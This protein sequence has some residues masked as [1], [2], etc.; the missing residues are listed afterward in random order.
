MDK[1]NIII[2]AILAV[3][4]AAGGLYFMRGQIKTSVYRNETGKLIE[5]LP[6]QLAEKYGGEI[7]YTMDKFWSCYEDKI[8]SQNDM[9]D[10]M[11]RLRTQALE[12]GVAERIDPLRVEHQLARVH[13]RGRDV[14]GLTQL[15]LESDL[16]E[17]RVVQREVHSRLDHLLHRRGQVVVG[18]QD[19]FSRVTSILIL[20]S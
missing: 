11:D 3:L 10:V 18:H 8:V 9:T 4:I 12:L 20:R 7:D 14:R 13:T 2:I 5:A 15:E 6:T 16:T 19:S 1:R 17:E